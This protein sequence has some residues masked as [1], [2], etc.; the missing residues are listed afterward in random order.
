MSG[1]EREVEMRGE[2]EREREEG[3]GDREGG[4]GVMIK[5]CTSFGTV[6][7]MYSD[8]CTCTVMY[9]SV[10]QPS[11]AAQLLFSRVH[12]VVDHTHEHINIPALFQARGPLP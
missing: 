6:C 3:R 1:K 8:V 5:T 11:A 2:G 7:V 4:R 12:A 9:D 10:L